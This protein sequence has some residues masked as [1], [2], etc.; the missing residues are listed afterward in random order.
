M[1]K[2]AKYFLLD[3]LFWFVVDFTTTTAIKDAAGYYGIYM[4]SIL[5][6]YLGCP[7]VFAVLIYKFNIGDKGLFIATVIEIIVVEIIF[8][9]NTLFFTFPMM[10]LAIA[11]SLGIYSFLTFVP[12]WI[13]DGELQAHKRVTILLM[14]VWVL[15]SF[16]TLFGTG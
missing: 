5:I 10:I 15:I 1:A 16:A 8:A 11:V 3:V 6:F 2:L 4:P 13:V 7:F 14:V 9:G 12:K